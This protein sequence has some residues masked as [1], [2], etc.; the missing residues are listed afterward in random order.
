MAW[1][2]HITV[3]TSLDLDESISGVFEGINEDGALLL[4]LAD[5]TVRHLV[6]GD[7]FFGDP[8]NVKEMP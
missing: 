3:R 5:G 6:V 4:R 7:V 1:V 2:E 8:R